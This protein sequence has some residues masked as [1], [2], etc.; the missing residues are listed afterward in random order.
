MLNFTY[1]LISFITCSQVAFSTHRNSSSAHLEDHDKVISNSKFDKKTDF[2]FLYLSDVNTTSTM[3]CDESNH[4]Q[5][6]KNG[7]SEN[8]KMSCRNWSSNGYAGYGKKDIPYWINVKNIG[9]ENKKELLISDIRY[10][11]KIWNLAKIEDFGENIVNF[12]EVG[13]GSDTLPAPINGK[14]VLE[15]KNEILDAA[16]KFSSYYFRI[17]VNF[18]DDF[19]EMRPGRNIDTIVHELGHVL[20]LNDL[21]EQED[22][23]EGTHKALME[24]AR[25]TTENTL[26]DALT[27]HDIQGAAYYNGIHVNHD[28]RRYYFDNGKY[29][30]VCFYCDITEKTTTKSSGSSEFVLSSS[31]DHSYEPMISLGEKHWLKCTNCYKVKEHYHD[32]TKTYIDYNDFSH[33]SYCWCGDFIQEKHSYKDHYCICGRYTSDHDFHDPYI[34]KT[35]EKHFASCSCGTK[36]LFGH[37]VSGDNKADPWDPYK[38]CLL[39]KGDASRGFGINDVNEIATSHSNEDESY[40]LN[41]GVIVLNGEDLE[42][43]SNGLLNPYDLAI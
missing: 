20:G 1:I 34:W 3:G 24:Y 41:N 18:D 35:L 43:F 36:S 39:C 22:E 13:I 4:N 31:C 7:F 16:G 19:G 10:Q 38:K 40:I 26:F 6:R 29:N 33:R 14:K 11:T 28:F 2:E 15:I 27:Y 37:I 23:N 21:D 25:R 32:Y 42:N 12:Y 9:D 5:E 17:R 8:Y 30:N